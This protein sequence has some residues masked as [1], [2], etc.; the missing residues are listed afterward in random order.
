[1]PT[2][3][4]GDKFGYS[5]ATS[6][7]ILVFIMALNYRKK[8]SNITT[9]FGNISYSYYLI[10]Q[11]LGYILISKFISIGTLYGQ[12]IAIVVLGFV[13]ILIQKYVELPT[14]IL[15]RKFVK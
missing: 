10:H 1:L 11:V 14:S 7:S 13:S 2:T 6:L 9:F 3:I 5:A 12:L 15:G 8:I 4:Y